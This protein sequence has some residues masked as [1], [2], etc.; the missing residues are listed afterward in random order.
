MS[1]DERDGL[2]DRLSQTMDVDAWSRADGSPFLPRGAEWADRRSTSRE[3]A[4]YAVDAGWRP[5]AD[6][7]R[8]ALAAMV[9]EGKAAGMYADDHGAAGFCTDHGQPA[10][11]VA[12]IQARSDRVG[13]L[14]GRHDRLWIDAA[15]ASLDDVPDLLAEVEWR[16][17]QRIVANDTLR[18]VRAE[19]ERLR[20]EGAIWLGRSAERLRERDALA[21]TVARVEAREAA[22]REA[23]ETLIRDL[24]AG[25]ADGTIY[26]Y[27]QV[28]AALRAALAAAPSET[29]GTR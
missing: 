5:D 7:R 8:E 1:T 22:L 29:A 15:E 17:S 4:G 11:D 18:S 21:A 16:D 10:L 6:E 25:R 2:I 20:E 3:W 26:T 28:Q 14:D 24:D 19:I 27:G 13:R 9:R 12:A 23:V